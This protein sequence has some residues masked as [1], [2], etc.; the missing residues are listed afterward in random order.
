VAVRETHEE[1]AFLLSAETLNDMRNAASMPVI[2]IPASKY[3]LHVLELRRLP[4]NM[5]GNIVDQFAN[6]QRGTTGGPL[7]LLQRGGDPGVVGLAWVRASDLL[8][9]SPQNF[10][11]FTQ[12]MIKIIKEAGILPSFS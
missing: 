11:R 2:W 10:H 8:D 7:P 12:A 6:L 3:A 4:A 9:N 5:D 1:T